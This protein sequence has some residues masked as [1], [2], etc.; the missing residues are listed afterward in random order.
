[1]SLDAPMGEEDTR[2]SDVVADTSADPSKVAGDLLRQ[3]ADLASALDDL[4]ENERIV[5]RRRFGLEG[6]DPETLEVIGRRLT[7]TRERVRQIERAA[8]RKLRALLAA[9]GVHANDLW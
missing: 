1:V 4:A 6:D 2:L 9:R 7:L 3:R 8:L 5:L